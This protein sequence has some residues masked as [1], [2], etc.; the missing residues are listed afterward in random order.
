[1]PNHVISEVIFRDAD[2]AAQDAIIASCCDVEG[3]VDLGILIPMPPHI[4]IGNVGAHHARLGQNALDWCRENWG[5]KWGAYRH[6]PTE[7]AEATLTLRFHT[8]WS[9]PYPWLV[10][11]F[12]TFKLDFDHNW[13]DE[14]AEKGVTG[15]WRW[16]ALA[17][18]DFKEEPWT[19]TQCDEAMQRH[20]HKLLWGV[21]SFDDE[22]A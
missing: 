13:L 9:P 3:H 11:V 16:R 7:R 6:L 1:M 10:A 8:A 20:L 12:N 18:N 4:W 21:E 14:G 17:S 15:K 22:A 5:T 2:T 19:E